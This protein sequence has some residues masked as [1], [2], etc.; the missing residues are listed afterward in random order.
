MSYNDYEDN[1]S[2]DNQDGDVYRSPYDEGEYD[3]D[4]L[5][6]EPEVNQQVSAVASTPGKNMIALGVILVVLV[7]IAYSFIFSSGDAD[8][9]AKDK[10]QAAKTYAG[11]KEVDPEVAEAAVEPPAAED[12]VID[13]QPEIVLPAPPEIPTPAPPPPPPAPTISLPDSGSSATPPP[14][15]SIETVEAPPSVP[16][17]PYDYDL[18]PPPGGK[19]SPLGLL[20]EDDEDKMTREQRIMQQENAKRQANSLVYGGG[21]APTGDE[22]N[23]DR[24][25][26]N[27]RSIDELDITSADQAVATRVGNTASLVAQGKLIEAVLETAIHTDFPGM[28][29]ATVARD[30]YSESGK[31][32]LIPK[33]SRLVGSYES[34]VVRG[35]SRV[36]IIWGR[37]IRPDGVDIALDSPGTDQLGRS[38]VEGRVDS[39]F[40]EVF[41]QAFL[42]S[43]LTTTIA[44]AADQATDNSPVTSTENTDGSNRTSG[45]VSDFAI[46]EA[47]RD[48]SDAGKGYLSELMNTRPSI[49]IDQ[50]TRLNVFVNRDLLFPSEVKFI[51]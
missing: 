18:V 14:G 24:D 38:G 47:V 2:R 44:I 23:A 9:E 1:Q 40:F 25:K 8:K 7:Y 37:L 4:Y 11:P 27:A 17:P 10:Q 31:N 26:L 41:G 35:Q 32:I 51:K 48:I 43:A 15:T 3:D 45:A 29:R 28:L 33:G 12:L 21:P 22:Q 30:V 50:G 34:N 36:Y 46:A 5:N 19:E 6:E 16:A 20:I 39:K 49:S 42:L 13:V